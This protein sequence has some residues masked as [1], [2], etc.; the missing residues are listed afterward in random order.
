MFICFRVPPVSIDTVEQHKAMQHWLEETRLL[1]EAECTTALQTKSIFAELQEK[2]NGM[3]S[4][5]TF[6]LRDLLH[7]S[8]IIHRQFD[9]IKE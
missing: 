7:K 8:T 6:S 2:V 1:Y 9:F 5:L 3:A 4:T